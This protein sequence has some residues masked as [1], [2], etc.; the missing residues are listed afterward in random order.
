VGGQE[1]SP[2]K[3]SAPSEAVAEGSFNGRRDGDTLAKGQG[4][5]T[6]A[7]ERQPET[8]RRIQ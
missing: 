4:E 3:D 1:Q 7:I 8:S 2:A 5:P 6:L